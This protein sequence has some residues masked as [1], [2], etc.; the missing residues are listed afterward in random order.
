MLLFHSA[1]LIYLFYFSF[2]FFGYSSFL[3]AFLA[4]IILGER[5]KTWRGRQASVLALEAVSIWLAVCLLEYDLSRDISLLLIALA[6]SLQNATTSTLDI[7]TI[8]TTN[9]TGALVD[10]GLALGQIIREGSSLHL[11]KLA[12]RFPHFFSFFIGTIL[13]GLAFREFQH[14]SYIFSAVFITASSVG[15]F[16][17]MCMYPHRHALSTKGPSLTSP[18]EMLSSPS[19]DSLHHSY[20]NFDLSSTCSFDF[21]TSSLPKSIL[22]H[23]HSCKKSLNESHSDA[24]YFSSASFE[25]DDAN[26][27]TFSSALENAV[28]SCS[29]LK[30]SS[31]ADCFREIL[32]LSNE[33]IGRVIRR[34]FQVD[35]GCKESNV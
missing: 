30:E 3:G 19:T 29:R 5:R 27:E 8:K 31:S 2:F 32:F 24:S 12:L 10:L 11:W 7:M 17:L 33:D 23:S 34:V 22:V 20:S 28:S 9:M 26:H 35:D 21:S 1:Q 25:F 14:N 13:G 4:G 6:S 16:V 18:N 15:S